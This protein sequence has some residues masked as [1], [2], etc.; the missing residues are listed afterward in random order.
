MQPA[1]VPSSPGAAK[2]EPPLPKKKRL[3]A[4]FRN[5]RAEPAEKH[6]KPQEY[7]ASGRH[8]RDEV[9]SKASRAVMTHA[10]EK[11]TAFFQNP[12]TSDVVHEATT[13]NF[14]RL[15]VPRKRHPGHRVFDV[16]RGGGDGGSVQFHL[17]SGEESESE[18]E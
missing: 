8:G 1:R 15:S 9:P 18:D 7:Y 11:I 17:K 4:K 12:D 5:L 13:P 2:D 14:Q 3:P 16:H 10:A 6:V